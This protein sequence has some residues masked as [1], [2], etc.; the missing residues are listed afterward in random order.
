MRTAARSRRFAGPM[1]DPAARGFL[2]IY[3]TGDRCPGCGGAH[4]TIGRLLAECARCDTALPLAAPMV[5]G[6]HVA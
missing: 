6:W 3:R 4:W 5:E 1:A 2:P